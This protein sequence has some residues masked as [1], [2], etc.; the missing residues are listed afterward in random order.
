LIF[1]IELDNF[2][3]HKKSPRNPWEDNRGIISP[4]YGRDLLQQHHLPYSLDRTKRYAFVIHL[5]RNDTV[6]IN[7]RG[8]SVRIELNLPD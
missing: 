7:T 6:A 8:K 3:V 4:F 1:S 2:A 5:F